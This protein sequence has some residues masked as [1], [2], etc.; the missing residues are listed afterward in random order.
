MRQAN[1]EADARHKQ[2]FSQG[3]LDGYAASLTDVGNMLM[4][5]DQ[6]A[7]AL[8]K[9][10]S[11]RI[12]ATL[13]GIS[14][15]PVLL[16]CALNQ[17]LATDSPSTSSPV[18]LTLPESARSRVPSLRARLEEVGM[19]SVTVEFHDT[20]RL[21][22][23]FGDQIAE[24]EPAHFALTLELPLL[25]ASSRDELADKTASLAQTLHKQWR[26][27]LGSVPSSA[28]IHLSQQENTENE[29]HP[30]HP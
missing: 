13:T 25:S 12:R 14:T 29:D 22:I 4:Q 21:L 19:T 24:F 26:S 3:Y 18:T 9:Q 2:A 8:W 10:M 7:S 20:P 30:D 15:H 23:E 1:A 28:E 17:W 27:R 11:D 6:L 16:E 5:A